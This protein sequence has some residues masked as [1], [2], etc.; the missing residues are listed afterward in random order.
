[1]AA[2]YKRSVYDC[3]SLKPHSYEHSRGLS[4]S[5]RAVAPGEAKQ[6][7]KGTYFQSGD[8]NRHLYGQANR[9]RTSKSY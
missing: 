6:R 1:M 4:P 3:G 7:E 9:G 8:S 2:A 5:K